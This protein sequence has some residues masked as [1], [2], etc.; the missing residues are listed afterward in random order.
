M[1]HVAL[2]VWNAASQGE[3]QLPKLVER[4]AGALQEF[5]RV[6]LQRGEPYTSHGSCLL[7]LSCDV[8]S[9]SYQKASGI[10]AKALANVEQ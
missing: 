9:A 8:R 4:Q 10:N 2:W 7:S 3:A 5:Q 1:R 6:G